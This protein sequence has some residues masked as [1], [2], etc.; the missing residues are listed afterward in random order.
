MKKYQFTSLIILFAFL[1]AACGGGGSGAPTPTPLPPLVSYQKAIYP[2]EKGS[3]VSDM[4]ITGDVVHSKQDELFFRAPGYVNRISVKK[5]DVVKKGDILAELQIDDLLNQLQQAQIDLEVAQANLAEYKAQQEYNIKKAE[6]D[7]AILEKRVEQARQDV[8]STWG[9]TQEMAQLNL[10]IAEL[11]LGLAQL[12][13]QMATLA[14]NPYMEQA[15][16]RSQLAVERLEGLIAERQIVAPYDGI[17]LKTLIRP[18]QEVRAF[19]VMVGI[20]DPAELVIRTPFDWDLRDILTKDTIVNMFMTSD[21]EEGSPVK[22]LPN[23]LPASI[24][25]EDQSQSQ[26]SGPEFMYYSLP[27][28]ITT[29]DIPVGRTVF[30]KIL[31]GQ[32]D[33]TLLLPPAAIREYKGFYFVIVVDEDVRRRVEIQKIGLKSPERWEI[34]ADLEEGDQVLGP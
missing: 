25:T 18:G 32:K 19:D 2:V 14:V 33:D 24:T 28:N 8:E 10:D 29:E 13:L 12:A 34:V 11:N 31:L 9:K 20:D 1:L 15:V 21:A 16:T 3:I 4:E 22:Y 6:I 7:V 27:E 30:L 5:G 17:V 26:T 23:F